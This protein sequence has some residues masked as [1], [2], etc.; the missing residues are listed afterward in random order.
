MRTSTIAIALFLLA[1]CGGQAPEDRCDRPSFDDD[2]VAEC[3]EDAGAMD[4]EDGLLPH[5]PDPDPDGSCGWSYC[6][7]YNDAG[8]YGIDT[9]AD[10]AGQNPWCA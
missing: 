6:E 7:A 3:C 4:C 5:I 1:G 2:D 9:Y 8:C 10:Y